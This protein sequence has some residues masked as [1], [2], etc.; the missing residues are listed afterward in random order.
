FFAQRTAA[1]AVAL[2]LARRTAVLAQAGRRT[3]AGWHVAAMAV[4][5]LLVA[6]EGAARAVNV[7]SPHI[8]GAPTRS[9]ALWTSRYVSLNRDG[10]RDTDWRAAASKQLRIVALGDSFT[11]GYGINRAED[12]FTEVAERSLATGGW[13]IRVFNASRPDAH[14]RDEIDILDTATQ[15]GAQLVVVAYVFNDID[16]AAPPPPDPIF[17]RGGRFH[18]RD[19]ARMVLSTS[20]LANEFILRLRAVA[21]NGRGDHYL[22]AYRDGATLNAHLDTLAAL[23]QKARAAHAEFRLVPFDIE[24]RR[25]AEYLARDVAFL[26]A[27]E[28]RGISTWNLLHTFDGAAY[29][30]LIVNKWDHH[31]NVLAHR[32]FGLALADRIAHDS[33]LSQLRNP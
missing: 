6:G 29:D 25:S 27:C 8:Q 7:I 10:F 4:L 2:L 12:R 23:A 30:D 28:S 17:G 15:L 24:P 3:A 19:L 1:G 21:L 18:Q 32:S 33:T 16:E 14:T 11:F 9:A 5:V 31:P 22:E 13:P 26:S 20:H